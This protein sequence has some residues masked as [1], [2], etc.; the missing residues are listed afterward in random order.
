META[1]YQSLESGCPLK[2]PVTNPRSRMTR[3]S[4]PD[5]DVVLVSPYRKITLA[6]AEVLPSFSTEER[7]VGKKTASLFGRCGWDSSSHSVSRN[8]LRSERG[9]VGGR[10]PRVIALGD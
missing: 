6:E 1:V 2:L 10:D 9:M 3:H 7:N 5:R 4:P 8:R